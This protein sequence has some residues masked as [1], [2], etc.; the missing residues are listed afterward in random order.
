MHVK[1]I[2]AGD[3]ERRIRY[4]LARNPLEAERQKRLRDKALEEIRTELRGKPSARRVC[5]LVAHQTY[6]RYLKL[7]ENGKTGIDPDK[8]RQEER[9]DGKY[10]IRTSDDTLTAEDVALGYKQLLEVEDAFRTLK[11]H[12]ELWPIHHRLSDRIR[13]HVLL[14]WLVL[15]LI[16]VRRPGRTAPGPGSA[17]FCSACTRARW[18]A[19]K[20]GSSSGRRRLPSRRP[21]SRC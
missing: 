19:P 6:G 18:L 11:T 8:V 9:L 17:I 1:E 3:G 16:R 4:I 5:E 13:A 2:E 15:M 14:C 20:A 12:L 10:L 21:F 7:G